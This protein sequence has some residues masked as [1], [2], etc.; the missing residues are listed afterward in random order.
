MIVRGKLTV[1]ILTALQ[2]SRTGLTAKQLFNLTD[3]D[4]PRTFHTYLSML[5]KKQYLRIDGKLQCEH[6]FAEHTCYR[7]DE[8]GRLYLW[9]R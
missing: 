2:K 7:I 3:Y 8:Q 1:Q 4:D 5:V 6:C 9:G